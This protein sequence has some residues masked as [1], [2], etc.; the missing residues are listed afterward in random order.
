MK[1]TFELRRAG[2]PT[3]LYLGEE[4]GIGRQIKHA[5]KSGI[6]IVVICGSDERARGVVTLKDLDAGLKASARLADRNEWRTTRPGQFEVPRDQM[7]R[8]IHDLIGV[9]A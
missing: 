3:E 7:V 5:D 1:L 6:P 9:G 2:I 4:R 8:A